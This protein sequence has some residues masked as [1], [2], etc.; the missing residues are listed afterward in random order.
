MPI[1]NLCSKS[2]SPRTSPDAATIDGMRGTEL[3]SPVQADWAD[4]SRVEVFQSSPQLH[5]QR[6]S[7]RG[8][9]TGQAQ[10]AGESGGDAARHR[11]EDGLLR[12]LRVP[13]RKM[14][15]QQVF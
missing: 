6:S 2:V 8:D 13:G 1:L 3:K 7:S 5:A 11:D 12:P 15:F 9:L 10:G 14:G 4:S